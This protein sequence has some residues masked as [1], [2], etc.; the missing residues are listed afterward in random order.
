MADILLVKGQDI[1]AQTREEARHYL[2]ITL[3]ITQ[4]GNVTYTSAYQEKE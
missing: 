2:Q 1:H 4:K 3:D